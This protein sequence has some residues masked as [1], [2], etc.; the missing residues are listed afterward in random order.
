MIMIGWTMATATM[1][2]GNGYAT[3][4]E[5]RT[6][7]LNTGVQTLSLDFYNNVIPGSIVISSPCLNVLSQR[8]KDATQ[9]LNGRTI[10]V[11]TTNGNVY[12]G[13]V[14]SMG[15]NIMITTSTQTIIIP[16][17]NVD[18]I[19][20][21]GSSL[22]KLTLTV[23]SQ[24]NDNSNLNLLYMVNGISWSAE[25]T[26]VFENNQ[27]KLNGIAHITNTAGD[28]DD[29]DVTLVA[30]NINRVQP[31]NYY[32]WYNKMMYAEETAMPTDSY[33]QTE[34]SQAYE[35]H[36][37]HVPML[38]NLKKNETTVVSIVS[39]N[40]PAEKKYTYTIPYWFYSEKE[41]EPVDV[42]I[43][44]ANTKENNGAALPSG[45]V[46]VY[47]DNGFNGYMLAGE[48]TIDNT[49]LG[50]DVTINTGKAF[51]ILASVKNT[52]HKKYSSR[53][54][55]DSYE[56][57]LTNRKNESVTVEVTGEMP[58]WE[59]WEIT[60]SSLSYTKESA[61]KVKWHVEI[62]KNSETTFTYSV[63]RWW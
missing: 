59:N 28:Y 36:T 2:I 3:V 27:L 51:D 13:K 19:V 55:E 23:D 4:N 62:P 1:T 63:K 41:N 58:R 56:I 34:Q 30:G 17:D 53:V 39:M 61:T 31:T 15:N 6:V 8:Y 11:T 37:Y 25:Y 40:V 38:V 14:I 22:P 18:N 10:T 52:N 7:N 48:D 26:A 60:Q 5:D 44:F 24:C 46:K 32:R 50:E 9:T 49:P 47:T 20:Y 43:E 35:Y 12:T 21:S 16:M 42:S 45:T 29:V 57:T 54:E 33:Q